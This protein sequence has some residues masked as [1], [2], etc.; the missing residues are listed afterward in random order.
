MASRETGKDGE[1]QKERERDETSEG[2]MQ[3]P[4]LACVCVFSSDYGNVAQNIY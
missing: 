1:R 3:H 2:L 4:S